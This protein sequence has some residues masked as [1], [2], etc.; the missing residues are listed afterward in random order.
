MYVIKFYRR[1]NASALSLKLQFYYSFPHKEA[2]LSVWRRG[3]LTKNSGA[4][5]L[6]CICVWKWFHNWLSLSVT[7]NSTAVFGIG[8]FTSRCGLFSPSP[9][10]LFLTLS[11]LALSLL[12]SW[13]IFLLFSAEMAV[14]E[15]ILVLAGWFIK[16]HPQAWITA[17][18]F[19]IMYYHLCSYINIILLFLKCFLIQTGGLCLMLA[20]VYF[21]LL[22]CFTVGF[23]C[24]A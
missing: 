19:N 18:W 23:L 14:L 9:A 20:L 6:S 22:P 8:P 7:Q 24:I 3:H 1:F 10:S 2:S 12:W 16:V 13:G 4:I 5:E 15:M 17:V 21:I 11:L